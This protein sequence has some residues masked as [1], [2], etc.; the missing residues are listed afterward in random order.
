[1]DQL[2]RRTQP[3]AALNHDVGKECRGQGW[4]LLGVEMKK[5]PDRRILA[6]RI[7]AKLFT[8]GAGK[9]AG[10]LVLEMTPGLAGSGWLEIG[11]AGV[12]EESLKTEEKRVQRRKEPKH[13]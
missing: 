2:R 11:V 8:D 10:R 4:P 13:A 3:A 1:M 7:A 12:I 9:R 5:K 6:E